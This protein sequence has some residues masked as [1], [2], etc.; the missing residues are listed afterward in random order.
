MGA[1]SVEHEL[2]VQALD[3]LGVL[4]GYTSRIDVGQ[5]LRPDVVR[6][7]PRRPRLFVAD[8]K[9]TEPPGLH[10]THVRLHAYMVS[11][12]MWTRAGFQVRLALAHRPEPGGAQEWL[13][14][15]VSLCRATK[16]WSAD[17]GTRQLAHDTMLTWIDLPAET[18][19][20]VV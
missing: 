18:R 13:T 3:A 15:L 20:R 16:V 10:A 6:L 4:A 2:R 14:V 11:V 7:D 19:Q 12:R 5:Q 8:A 1:P 9:A 17:A